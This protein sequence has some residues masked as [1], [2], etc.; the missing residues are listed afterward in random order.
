M[1]FTVIPM[2]QY[3]ILNAAINSY[4]SRKEEIDQLINEVRA[5]ASGTMDPDDPDYI[6]TACRKEIAMQVRS[7]IT[8]GDVL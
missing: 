1:I 6:L 8:G 4:K 2:I 5:I 3:A 7:T